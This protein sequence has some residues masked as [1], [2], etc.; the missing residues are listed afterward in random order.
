MQTCNNA[1]VSVA[2]RVEP[3][4]AKSLRKRQFDVGTTLA[5][6]VDAIRADEELPAGFDERGG[7][8]INGVPFP[9][10]MWQS[11]RPKAGT[12]DD[13][14]AVTLHAAAGDP[15]SLVAGA[16]A[17]FAQTLSSIPII[18]GLLSTGAALTPFGNL[19]VGTALTVGAQ[20][21][22][23]ALTK[24]PSFARATQNSGAD[25]RSEAASVEGNPYAPNG[26]I[27]RVI[28]TRKVYPQFVT[29]P[30]IELVG[31]DEFVEV[32]YS[33]AGPHAW[34]DIRIGDAPIAGT[35]DVES[36]TREGF[37]G[38]AP[39]DLVTR[40]S[41][42]IE[43]SIKL[44]VH[45][46]DPDAKTVLADQLTPG[47]S[48]PG[49]H[50]FASRAAPDEIWIDIVMPQG[51]ADTS[52]L[53]ASRGVPLRIQIRRRGDTDWIN[54]PD[55]H[56]WDSFIGQRRRTINIIWGAAP[57]RIE[58]VPS[59][60]GFC[61]ATKRAPGQTVDPV[62]SDYAA[63]SHFSAGSGNDTL[64]RGSEAATNLQNI[65]L[66]KSKATIYLDEGTFPKG[67]YDIRIKRGAFYAVSSF[68]KT[69]QTYS[70]TSYDLF[71]YY[72]NSTTAE[73]PFSRD[74]AGDDIYIR[75]V[76]SVWNEHPV[77]LKGQALLA[78]R[79]KNRRVEQV[80]AVCSG[81]VE[82]WDGTDWATW[83]T[84]SNPAPHFRDVL[85]GSANVD[86][87]PEDLI[88]DTGLVAWRQTCID[89]AYTC[90]SII[91]G[92]GLPEVLGLLASCGFA[93]PYQ[94]EVWGVSEDADTS[95]EAPVQV[96]TPRNARDF[97]IKKGFARLPDGFRVSFRDADQDYIEDELTVKRIGYDGG[98]D[99]KFESLPIEGITDSNKVAVRAQFDIDQLVLRDTFYSCTAAYDA[100]VCRRGSLVAFHHDTLEDLAGAARVVDVITENGTVTALKLE[101]PIEVKNEGYWA[102]VTDIS[103]ITDISQIG[104]KTGISIRDANGSVTT[105]AISNPTGEAGE[106]T[107]AT[108][109]AVAAATPGSG[110]DGEVGKITP[111]I[112]VGYGRL[113]SEYKRLRV[114]AIDPTRGAHEYNIICVNEAPELVRTTA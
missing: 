111:G 64:Y 18:G 57:E 66:S 98:T 80:S 83:T 38:D 112:L 72:F 42:T 46:V 63:H 101:A 78:I 89:N 76:A 51:L 107:L 47:N 105:H 53:N 70:G 87:L 108:P 65:A 100:I 113:G 73:I 85:A 56:L 41:K 30:L 88:D 39:I 90:D 94:S 31:D 12:A 75:H 36:E 109:I 37:A 58:A 45:D 22:T 6:I 86:P 29:N 114:F 93:Q 8:C 60:E 25:D 33:L 67:I 61:F 26:S 16:G 21:A 15:V 10:S 49:L 34:S 54:L 74:N 9:R 92:R 5:A 55:L 50:T 91:E 20:L 52:N 81:Y 43:Y 82:D 24:P 77:P 103:A 69:A 71:G 97:S 96:F 11:A 79:A 40:Q 1:K 2:W 59:S 110:D 84:T 95:A 102:D 3:F 35:S 44:S 104:A 48:V 23:Q 99:G 14:V 27:S 13:P 4:D 68:S 28:G 62:G 17:L 106:I 32:V 7:I 19:L